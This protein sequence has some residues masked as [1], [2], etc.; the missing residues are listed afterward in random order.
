MDNQLKIFTLIMLW[1]PDLGWGRNDFNYGSNQA[2]QRKVDVPIIDRKKCQETLQMT[3]LGKN[4]RLDAGFMCAGKWC[5]CRF[6]ILF[7]WIL[8]TFL[9]GGESGKGKKYHATNWYDENLN[10]RFS[11]ACTGDGG[12]PMVSLK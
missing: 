10:K 7:L 3:R 1:K 8:K 4:F 5:R 11:D 12:A 9:L 6:Q 2:M